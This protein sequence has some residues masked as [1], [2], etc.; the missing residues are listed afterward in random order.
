MCV[1]SEGSCFSLVYPDAYRSNTKAEKWKN[2][3]V[4]EKALSLLRQSNFPQVARTN[5]DTCKLYT[6]SLITP[7]KVWRWQVKIPI[8]EK[9]EILYCLPLKGTMRGNKSILLH[10]R[11]HYLFLT[12]VKHP[13]QHLASK[14]SK[15]Q[16]MLG[17]SPLPGTQRTVY[18]EKHDTW[19][20]VSF[21][22]LFFSFS[23]LFF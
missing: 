17:L 16:R 11:A 22:L 6:F 23:F 13:S 21:F 4:L 20:S 2:S 8:K 1:A 9:F 19:L 5:L 15:P 10:F 7:L 14:I 12:L 18:Q 3:W